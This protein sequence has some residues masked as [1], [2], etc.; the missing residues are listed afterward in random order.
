[1]PQL[2]WPDLA[3]GPCNLW[4]LPP[5]WKVRATQHELDV[6]AR[7]AQAIQP[8]QLSRSPSCAAIPRS[9]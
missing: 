8:A 7:R 3:F 2:S 1:M 5:A 4:S 9:H 6:L